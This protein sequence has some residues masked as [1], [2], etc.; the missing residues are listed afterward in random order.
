MDLYLC[1][2]TIN[3]NA[4]MTGFLCV[5]VHS[6]NKQPNTEVTRRIVTC[7]YLIYKLTTCNAFFIVSS[8]YSAIA[9]IQKLYKHLLLFTVYQA[10]TMLCIHQL[11]I[12]YPL[13]SGLF[14]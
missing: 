6:Q 13:T 1:R 14:S 3:A 12:T 8:V 9:S 5:Q 4:S 10:F 2:T 11:A 7:F